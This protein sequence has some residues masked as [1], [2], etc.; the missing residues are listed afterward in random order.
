MDAFDKFLL[1]P[2]AIGPIVA[3]SLSVLA[4]LVYPYQNSLGLTKADT[5]SV[6]AVFAGIY[7]G[8]W[9]STENPADVLEGMPFPAQLPTFEKV[10]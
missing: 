2:S 8:L 6:V 4:L 7:T 9:M 5:A 1:G 10:N 3:I